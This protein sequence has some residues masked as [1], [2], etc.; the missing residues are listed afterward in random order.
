[1]KTNRPVVRFPA[2]WRAYYWMRTPNQRKA[3]RDSLQMELECLQMQLEVL[4]DLIAEDE[5]LE[6]ISGE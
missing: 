3:V 4:N 2:Y 1:M 5:A 6:V